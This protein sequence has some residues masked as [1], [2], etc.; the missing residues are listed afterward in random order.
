M[1]VT[2]VEEKPQK[3]ATGTVRLVESVLLPQRAQDEAQRTMGV[4]WLED[5]A[6]N[7]VVKYTDFSSQHRVLEVDRP[8][9]VVYTE[10]IEVKADAPSVL[11]RNVVAV[12][13][14]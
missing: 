4:I 7:E 6:S 11:H 12:R 8:G 2:L 1:N 3:I 5:E 9:R 14:D 10:N 13:N